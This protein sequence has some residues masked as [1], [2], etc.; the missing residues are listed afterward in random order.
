MPNPKQYTVKLWILFWAQWDI[1]SHMTTTHV[2]VL[3][4]GPS[5]EYDV[6]LK[7]GGA[8]LS[9]LN[10][11]KYTPAD[12]LISRTGDWFMNGIQ[13]APEQ[14][15]KRVDVFFN[16]L[17]GEYGEDG[18]VQ[19]LLDAHGVPYTGS[20]VMPSALGMNK[21]LA[22]HAFEL[23]G[24]KT[25]RGYVL[26]KDEDTTEKVRSLFTEVS[27]PYVIKPAMGG[28]SVD[29]RVAHQFA[30]LQ[31]SIASL[32]ERHN[33]VM[34]EEFVRGREFTCG[35]IDS[36]ESQDVYPTYPIEI[37]RP[38]GEDIWSY[39]SKYNGLTREVCPPNIDETRMN[40]IQA[41]AVQAHT[42]LGLR[43]YSRSDFIVT[44]RA[45]YVL[46]VNSLPGLTPESLLPK[47]LKTAGFEFSD[48]LDYVLTLAM[49]KK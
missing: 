25:P 41:L 20:G 9:H 45:V 11:S 21:G 39:E 3:R 33:L 23:N 6:S 26:R 15:A 46:E 18:K 27:G 47:S 35:V 38:E 17:H 1:I 44:P 7:T 28:S 29:V 13:V 40:L 4:G 5:S 48:F 49:Q 30:E 43:H 12:I 34:V 16:A 14:A 8:V 19:Q 37:V 22:K 42:A 36:L 31:D 10:T 2:G 24:I 32:F